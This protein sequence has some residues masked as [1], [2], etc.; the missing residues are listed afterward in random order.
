MAEKTTKEEPDFAEYERLMAEYKEMC[1]R[2]KGDGVVSRHLKSKKRLLALQI[3]ELRQ[4]WRE[5][6]QAVGER[7]YFV[8]GDAVPMF[9][10][11]GDD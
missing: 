8:G 5:I 7:R 3:E 1:E 4:H 6:G 11:E 10:V 2:L 9:R